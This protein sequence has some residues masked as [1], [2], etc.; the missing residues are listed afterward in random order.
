M[1]FLNLR[2]ALLSGAV[3]LAAALGAVI[4]PQSGQSQEAAKTAAPDAWVTRCDDIKDGDK[5]TGKYC[6]AFQRL[7]VMEKDAAPETAQR[8]AEFAIGYPPGEKGKAKGALILPLGILVSKKTKISIDGKDVM[9]FATRYCDNSGCI[10]MMDLNNSIL[11]RMRKGNN[12]T[13]HSEAFTGQPLEITMSLK[14][15]STALDNAK[16]KS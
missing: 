6:E 7:S 2:T 14:G 10:A 16:P 4:L 11:D 8:L 1:N 13:I 15:F 5:V 12:M 9:E 3:I